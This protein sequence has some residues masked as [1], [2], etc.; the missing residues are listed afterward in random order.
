MTITNEEAPFRPPHVAAVPAWSLYSPWQRWG[1]FTILFWVTTS[2]SL[3]FYILS[4]LL[5]PIKREFGVSDTML[6]ILSGV[7]FALVYSV[8][9]LPIAR[10]ADYGNR[11]TLL[12]LALTGWSVMTAVCGLAQS[13][14]QL[15]LARFGVGVLEPGAVPA[16]LSL[17]ADYFPPERRSAP[18]AVLVN[19][20]SALGWLV[21]VGLGGFLAATYGWR[22]AFMLP[23]AAGLALAVIVRLTLAEPRCQLGF[24]GGELQPESFGQT[25]LE[26]RCKRSF[27]FTLVGISIYSIFAYGVTVFIPSFMIRSLH[28]TLAQVS[29]IWGPAI[30]AADIVGALVGGLLGDRLYRRDIRW[31]AWLPAITCALGL[32]LYWLAF[33]AS[34]LTVFIAVEFLAELIL[35]AG[36]PIAFVA[37]LAV[38]GRRRRAM[39]SAIMFSSQVLFGGNLGPLLAGALSDAF[40]SAQ[41]VE[42]LRYSLAII[43]AFLIPAAGAFYW[44]ANALPRDKEE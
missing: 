33:S 44:A 3:V 11:R 14:W 15:A 42:S 21:G 26:L 28:T 18:T 38:C 39:A 30:A 10:W 6:G 7:C 2:N 29:T 40:N 5:E 12:T 43:C 13:F 34:H 35:S 41:G 20:A 22:A 31:Y 25:I 32:P 24:P 23:G 9:A 19:G 27:L 1:F 16:A 4:V 37:A 8:T 36:I 17:I